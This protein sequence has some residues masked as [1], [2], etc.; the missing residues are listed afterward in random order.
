LGERFDGLFI[1]EV[2]HRWWTSAP[3]VT[4][5]YPAQAQAA[6]LELPEM[7]ISFAEI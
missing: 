3:L 5:I 7:R 6:T 4:A 2:E 1:R